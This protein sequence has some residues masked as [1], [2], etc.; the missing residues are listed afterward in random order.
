MGMAKN[1]PKHGFH[2]PTTPHGR[3]VR[4]DHVLGSHHIIQ[5]QCTGGT[6][7]VGSKNKIPPSVCKARLGNV[8]VLERYLEALL[9]F[10]QPTL[11][12]WSRYRK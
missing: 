6:A 8:A 4:K 2:L 5:M 3:E 12:L 1:G 9:W 10:C 11:E 7:D